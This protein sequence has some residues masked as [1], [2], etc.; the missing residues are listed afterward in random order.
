MEKGTTAPG[1]GERPIASTVRRGWLTPKAWDKVRRGAVGYAFLIP[2]LVFIGYFLYFPAYRA[3]TGAFTSWDGFNPPVYI[4][5]E[6][7]RQILDDDVMRIAARNNLIWATI[8]VFLAIIPAFVVAELIFHVKAVR[9]R[10][11]YRTLFVIP[12]IVPFI[13]TV[14]LWRYFYQG[15]GLINIILS[16][17]GLDGITQPWIADPDTALYALAFM[18]VPWVSAFNMLIFFAGLQGIPKEVLEAAELEGA[19]GLRRI[20]TIDVPLVL[21]Q[22]KLLFI[23]AL[24]TSGQNIVV[25][26]VMTD[27]GPGYSTYTVALAM[28]EAAV[29]YGDFGYSMAIAFMLFVV[30]LALTAINQ[31]FIRE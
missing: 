24:I 27:G 14:L 28:Y 10:Y 7:F 13:V 1:A 5:L 12:A 18:G 20:W 3:L 30:I 11:L 31:R 25:P 16:R 21:S 6:N 2:T 15:N 23:L 17:I 4:G 22:F 8:D 26:L 29:E 19:S 9:L